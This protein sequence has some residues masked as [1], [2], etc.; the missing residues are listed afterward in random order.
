MQDSKGSYFLSQVHQP[1]FLASFLWAVGSMVVFLL[2][3]KGVIAFKVNPIEFHFYTLS[4][5]VIFQAFIGFIFTTYPRFCQSD[6]IPKQRYM[7]LFYLLQIGLSLYFLGAFFDNIFTLVGSFVVLLASAYVVATLYKIYIQT[8]IYARHD[9]LWIL[10]GFIFGFIANALYF[11]GELHFYLFS[12]SVVKLF[13]DN[14]VVNIT[15]YLFLLFTT[16]SV[17]QRMVHFFSHSYAKKR[18]SFVKNSFFMLLAIVIVDNLTLIDEYFLLL[19]AL[20]ELILSIYLFL[21]FKRWKLGFKKAPAILKILH[22]ALFW[23]PVALL[24]NALADINYL[25]NADHMAQLGIHLIVLGFIVTMLIG[26][27]SRVTL[28]HSGQVPHADR[29]T[30][31]IFYLTQL[32]VVVRFAYSLNIGFDAGLNFLFDISATLWLLLFILWLIR[33]GS[34]LIFGKKKV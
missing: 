28:G 25:L 13:V 2:A 26:F 33:F 31:I 19:L 22:I 11:L 17:A 7:A 10:V 16:F 5:G 6:V 12:S 23:L 21:E 30:L 29:F 1:F 32:V 8:D 15:I 24:F 20:L 3:F 4:F 27:G 34:T 14:F 18:D 9:P